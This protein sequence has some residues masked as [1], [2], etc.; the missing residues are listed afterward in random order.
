MPAESVVQ[1]YVEKIARLFTHFEL[2]GGPLGLSLLFREE[3]ER[4][5]DERIALIDAAR[6]NLALG[7]QAIE[8]LQTEAEKS[9]QEIQAAAQQIALLQRDR[10]TLQQQRDEVKR[11]VAADVTAFQQLAGVP[12]RAAIRRERWIG[13]VSGVSASLMA[14]GIGWLITVILR[15]T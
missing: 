12:S 14:T 2:R 1:W 7:I 10:Q 5:V 13:F 3:A 9:R 4:S 8:E 6:A 11:I 15:A